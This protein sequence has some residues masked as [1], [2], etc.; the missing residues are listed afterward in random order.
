MT[1]L[2]IIAVA[3]CAAPVVML[4]LILYL[5]IRE[6]FAVRATNEHIDCAGGSPCATCNDKATCQRG[7]IRQPE[8]VRATRAAQEGKSHDN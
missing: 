5:A 7:C 6:T 3:A 4:L 2:Q 8:F 1:N